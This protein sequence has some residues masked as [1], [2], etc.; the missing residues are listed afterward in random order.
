MAEDSDMTMADCIAVLEFWKEFD[1]E[2]KKSE[3]EQQCVEMKDQKT[4]S[5]T[6]RKKLNELTKAFRNKSK[7]DQLN[8]VTDILKAYQEEIDQ[9]S[10]RSKLSES[11]FSA[12]HKSLWEAPDPVVA[13]EALVKNVG[14]S[15]SHQFEVERLKN[16]LTQYEEEFQQLKNQDITI[17]RLEDQ[18]NEFREQ[19]EDKVAEEVDRRVLEVE[20]QADNKVSEIKE[21]QKAAERRMLAALES[22]K[23]A[24]AGSERAQSHLFDVSAQAENRISGLLAENSILA[25]GSERALSRIA[26]LE[27]ELTTA[28][29]MLGS[30]QAK[31]SG[32]GGSTNASGSNIDLVAL[33]VAGGEDFQT[34]QLMVNELR[35]EIRKKEDSSRAEKQRL[36]ASIRD[37]NHQLSQEREV[38]TATKQELL[39]RPLKEDLL[40]LR[41]QLRLLQRV[42]FNADDDEGEEV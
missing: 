33:A 24:Q 20:Q 40:M 36:E 39:Q 9:L 37:L 10:R 41:K 3:L 18:L 13:F 2:N 14:A 31:N 4:A 21:A 42:V 16:E 15:S 12:I 30:L 19:I 34:L 22:M 35:Q 32:V 7:E 38:V 6:G 23:Q 28:R 26:E 1:L 17:R 27:A 11:A 25:E 5:I 8:G 29:N